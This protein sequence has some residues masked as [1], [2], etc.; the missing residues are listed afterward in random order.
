M[1][2]RFIRYSCFYR[3]RMSPTLSGSSAIRRFEGNGTI[4]IHD[5]ITF[6]FYTGLPHIVLSI[7]VP[8]PQRMEKP[9]NKAMYIVSLNII[10][11]HPLASHNLSSFPLPSLSPSLPPIISCSDLVIRSHEVKQEGYEVAH[12]GKCITVFSAPNYW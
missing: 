7:F 12:R 6:E 8:H 9:G 5:G 10:P 2:R 3:A 11:P 1:L 4:E